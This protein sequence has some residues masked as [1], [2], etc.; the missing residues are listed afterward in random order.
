MMWIEGVGAQ[1]VLKAYVAAIPAFLVLALP[2]AIRQQRYQPIQRQPAADAAI[3]WRRVAAVALMLAGTIAANVL[4][5][6]PA[7]GLWLAIA[8]AAC[9]TRTDFRAVSGALRGT[10]FLLTLVTAA[11]LMPVES[12][13]PATWQT[14]FGLG[15]ISAVFDNIPLTKLALEQGGYDAGILAF[16]VG[17]GGS[18]IWFGSSAGVALSS[19]FP[20]MRYTLR[21]LARAWFVPLGYIVGFFVM[22]LLTGWEPSIGS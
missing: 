17:F 22:L 5:E 10:L 18:M 1:T 12:L 15:W 6:L 13:P 7:L 8:C 16:A 21:W 4:I 3:E 19:L 14:T 20:E 2:A 11:S 9:F